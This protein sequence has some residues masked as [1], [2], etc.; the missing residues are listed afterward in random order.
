[1]AHT[2]ASVPAVSACDEPGER[3]RRQPSPP[4]YQRIHAPRNATLPTPDWRSIARRL[5]IGNLDAD[6]CGQGYTLAMSGG[7]AVAAVITGRL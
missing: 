2:T 5:G 3:M 4:G 6:L 7:L 1:V